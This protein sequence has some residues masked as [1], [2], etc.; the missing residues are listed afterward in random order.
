MS[1]VYDLSDFK[2]YLSD[3]YPSYR[4]DGLVFWQNRIPLP[5]DLFNRIFAEADI[6]FSH[7]L[8]HLLVAVIALENQKEILGNIDKK[9][10][11]SELPS[12]SVGVYVR[13]TA[14]TIGIILNTNRKYSNIA[15]ALADLL[16]FGEYLPEP[17]QLAKALCHQGKKYAR[18]YCS[19]PFREIINA[20]SNVFNDIAFDNTDMFGN[21]I[22]DHYNIYRSGFSDALAIIFNQLIDFRV[23]CA[24][25]STSLQRISLSVEKEGSDFNVDI[26]K[27]KDGSLWEPDYDNEHILRL[28]P[29]HPF[30]TASVTNKSI[31]SLKVLLFC[32]SKFEYSQ[33]SDSQRKLM[34][35]MRQ[36]IS[37]E[38]WIKYDN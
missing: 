13:E 16:S 7:Y 38:L 34:E 10:S 5:I 29:E 35:N 33:F 14:N 8:N 24:G 20:H 22:A 21:V 4:V 12:S 9:I 23:L 25:R 37:R 31:E 6:F 1:Y 15:V 27:T 26:K 32:L 18:I 2:R 17:N 36:E 28:N 3:L 30:F 11:F 19:S